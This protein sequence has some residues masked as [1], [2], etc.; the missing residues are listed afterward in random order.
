MLR[1]KLHRVQR[2]SSIMHERKISYMMEHICLSVLIWIGQLGY[3]ISPLP[4]VVEAA[5]LA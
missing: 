1:Q 4:E 2:K 5:L 3:L